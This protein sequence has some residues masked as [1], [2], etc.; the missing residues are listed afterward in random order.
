MARHNAASRAAAKIGSAVLVCIALAWQALGAGLP[1]TTARDAP[2]E[3]PTTAQ[4]SVP[5]GWQSW[6][7]ASAPD[8]VLEAGPAQVRRAL[9]A[10]EMSYSPLDGLGR[11]GLV[12]AS[13]THES[14]E[15]ASQRGRQDIEVDPVGWPDENP[16]V[17]IE[18]P[19]GSTYRGHFWNR[20][21]LLADSLGGDPTRENLVTGS[22][23][24]NA[25]GN[26]NE[27]G[28]AYGEQVARDWLDE[29]DGGTLYYSALPLYEGSERIPRAVIVDMF[30]SDGTVDMELIVYNA[31]KGYAIDYETGVVTRVD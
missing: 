1:A 25:G 6:D 28:M 31:A 9:E 23:M 13:L 2:V 19:D 11:P 16:K 4:A 5:D 17:S 27:G 18:T 21:H 29:H 12:A 30:S 15:R 20:S 22:R 8:Y 7:E 24:Q 26:D 10:G 3:S 14:R